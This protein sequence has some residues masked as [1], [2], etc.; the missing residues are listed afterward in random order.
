MGQKGITAG[1][2]NS[3]NSIALVRSQRLHGIG[4]VHSQVVAVILRSNDGI[5]GLVIEGCQFRTTGLILPQPF[6][7]L[8]LDVLNLFIGCCG[9]ILIYHRLAI[10]GL[11]LDHHAFAVQH[12]IKQIQ[13]GTAI[14]APFL[15]VIGIGF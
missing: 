9:G 3:L 1:G 13:E 5:I 15:G 8:L 10:V 6:L 11:I 4:T 2:N 7:E 14:G 12:G